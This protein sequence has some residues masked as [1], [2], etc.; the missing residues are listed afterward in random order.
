MK[1]NVRRLSEALPDLGLRQADVSDDLVAWLGEALPLVLVDMPE[2]MGHDGLKPDMDP[3]IDVFL[4]SRDEM[5]LFDDGAESLGLFVVDT[6]EGDPFGDETPLAKRL[7]VLVVMDR[8]E[9]ENRLSEEI[10]TDGEVWEHYLHEY[11]DSESATSFHEV[12]H[13]MLFAAN[14]GMMS[15][16]AVDT[17]H[18]AGDLNNDVFDM[19]TGY[20]VRGLMI[21][22]EEVWAESAEHA[23]EVMETWC[24]EVARRAAAK[25]STKFEKT[26]YQAAGI[27]IA[28]IAAKALGA[29]KGPE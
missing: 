3:E 10:D 17:A 27:D 29:G 22:G 13:A 23:N 11:E 1:I 18:G 24:E 8:E 21:D 25:A 16:N 9:I 15:P 12:A 28:G 5:D 14:S 7:R 19:T 26:F 4:C 6:P 20:G 2:Q